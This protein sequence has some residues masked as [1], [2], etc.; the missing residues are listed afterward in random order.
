MIHYKSVEDWKKNLL[1]TEQ[2]AQGTHGAVL[3][4]LDAK[5]GKLLYQSGGA[6]KSWVH[7]SGLAIA[8][9]KVYAVDHDSNVYCFGLKPLGK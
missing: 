8:D 5:A 9:G 3:Y 7:F 1:T 4:A 6:M 2:R